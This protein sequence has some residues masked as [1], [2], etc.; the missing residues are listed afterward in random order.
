M[1]VFGTHVKWAGNSKYKYYWLF[2]YIALYLKKAIK[3][4]QA[5][6]VFIARAIGEILSGK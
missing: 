4:K 3:V 6:V 1:Q 2:S 5:F